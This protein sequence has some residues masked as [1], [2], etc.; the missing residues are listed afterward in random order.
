MTPCLWWLSHPFFVSVTSFHVSTYQTN[1]LKVKCNPST[2]A[3]KITAHMKYASLALVK[4]W[5][6]II[7]F[8]VL[9]QILMNVPAFHVKMEEPV[10]MMSTVTL[11]S[12]VL[13]TE[14]YAVNKVT[15]ADQSLACIKFLHCASYSC[16]RDKCFVWKNIWGNSR[17]KLWG[18]IFNIFVLLNMSL[19]TFVS[20]LCCF[21]NFLTSLISI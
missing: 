16:I 5:C 1:E 8:L 9:K 15:H 3:R 19:Q 2:S 7:S 10:T 18:H 20:I 21:F 6:D 17:E 11:V 13:V 12:V 4:E 14:E